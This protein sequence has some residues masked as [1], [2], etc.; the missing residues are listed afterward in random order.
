MVSL[1]TDDIIFTDD[2]IVNR[3]F[4]WKVNH[5]FKVLHQSIQ[6]FQR[7]SGRDREESLKKISYDLCNGEAALA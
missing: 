2:I 1:L 4:P 7:I 3:C 6:R 5:K